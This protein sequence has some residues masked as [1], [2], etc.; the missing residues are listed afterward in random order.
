MYIRDRTGMEQPVPC[1]VPS[2]TSFC[3]VPKILSRPEN[4]WEG[5]FQSRKATGRDGM[6]GMGR[7]GKFLHSPKWKW[8]M[9]FYFFLKKI[10]LRD[11]TGTGLPCPESRPVPKCFLSRPENFPSQK[12]A[13]RNG[14]AG[15]VRDE[16]SLHRPNIGNCLSKFMY[17]TCGQKLLCSLE[18]SCTIKMLLCMSPTNLKY[19]EKVL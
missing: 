6:T 17:R 14:T 15:T 10:Y 7:D 16:K 9:M 4:F 13:G 1:P 3:P 18:S 11:G 19:P 8:E 5:K 12:A 2:Q